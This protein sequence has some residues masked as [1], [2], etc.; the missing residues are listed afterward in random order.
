MS[1]DHSEQWIGLLAAAEDRAR[2][3][4]H[5]ED[6]DFKVWDPYP[7]AHPP[8]V[9]L[10]GGV[11]VLIVS[12]PS[13]PKARG[14]KPV[15]VGG[16]T[17]QVAAYFQDT[18]HGVIREMRDQTAAILAA[19]P[20]RYPALEELFASGAT[21]VLEGEI[22]RDALA[23]RLRALRARLNSGQATTT[24]G[25]TPPGGV[26]IAD[27]RAKSMGARAT[28]SA[29]GLRATEN[30]EAAARGT[31]GMAGGAARA[32]AEA[33]NGVLGSYTGT[34]HNPQ[35]GRIDAKR[36]AAFLGI[37]LRRL[38]EALG[39]AYV[40][41]HKTPDS[42]GIQAVLRPL[43][44]IVEL[45]NELSSG[46]QDIKVW[47]NRPLRELEGDSPLATILA[48]EA[49]AVETLLWNVLEGIPA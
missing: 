9:S 26:A 1:P 14:A 4:Q 18:W 27:S 10:R 11:Q 28:P 40:N 35:S 46:P 48:G 7:A 42:P 12:I 32:N 30:E 24:I 33:G 29:R 36:V 19:V 45:L 8:Q 16:R 41:V 37:P 23:A 15:Q 20:A 49:D 25:E 31:T 22:T 47:L 44:Q 17:I 2:I 38:T 34:V 3:Q 13:Q 6:L 43:A 21:E 39:L 5:L